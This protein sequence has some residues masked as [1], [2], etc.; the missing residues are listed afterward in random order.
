MKQTSKFIIEDP[1][2][3][4]DSP[5]I[6]CVDGESTGE[7]FYP[8]NSPTISMHESILFDNKRD[9]KKALLKRYKYHCRENIYSLI[10]VILSL[11]ACLKNY[12]I[13]LLKK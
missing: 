3:F 9:A 2:F 1:I 12:L 10:V 7:F 8:K 13:V 4:G 6:N 11:M 5:Q